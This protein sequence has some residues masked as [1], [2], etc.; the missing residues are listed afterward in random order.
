MTLDYSE[1]SAYITRVILNSFS[2]F[3]FYTT[4]TFMLDY[5][6][7]NLAKVKEKMKGTSLEREGEE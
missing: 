1:S 4:S 6:E 2:M 5:F 3:I 7:A